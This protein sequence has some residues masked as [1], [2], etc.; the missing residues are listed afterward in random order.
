VRIARNGA[1]LTV[2]CSGAGFCVSADTAGH[3]I[4]TQGTVVTHRAYIE[5]L[6]YAYAASCPTTSFCMVM[7]DGAIEGYAKLS[8]KKYSPMAAP[9]ED[10]NVFSGLL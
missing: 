5:N 6:G 9:N 4:Q 1:Y 10:R 7:D 8:L 3:V 2:G